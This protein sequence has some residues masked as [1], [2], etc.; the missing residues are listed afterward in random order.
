[1]EKLLDTGKVRHIGVSN[2]D[3][4][5]MKDLI[6]HS[7][8]KPAVHQFELH[9]YLQQTKWVQ[10]HKDHGI[11]VTAYSPF[12]NLNPIYDAPSDDDKAPPLLLGNR[13]VENIALVRGCT[14]AQV[15]LVWG[16]HRGTS[17]IPKSS[18]AKRI[19]ENFAT[20]HCELQAADYEQITDLGD[21][22]T[23]RFNNPSEAWDVPLYEGLDDA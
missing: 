17:V 20:T 14:P 2:F 12:G 3:P 7:H 18:H 15:V 1:M 9:P 16:M 13:V 11:N 5:Q 8:T 22:Y 10:W 23:K 21:K 6:K 4:A 19:R